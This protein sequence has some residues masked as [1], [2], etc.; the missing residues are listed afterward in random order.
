MPTYR[1]FRVNEEDK[2]I[3]PPAERDCAT[4]QEA[5]IVAFVVMD[6]S[7][8][9]EVWSATRSVGRV[10]ASE[11][12][13]LKRASPNPLSRPK[14]TARPVGMCRQEGVRGRSK[15]RP[16]SG[17]IQTLYQNPARIVPAP[18]L[19]SDLGSKKD[20]AL[21]KAVGATICR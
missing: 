11:I 9:E 15:N 2:I 7:P 19:L 1:L 17:A 8:A 5:L 13:L 12:D 14:K 16:K 21:V 18:D 6:G 10:K 4:D 3:G 20:C